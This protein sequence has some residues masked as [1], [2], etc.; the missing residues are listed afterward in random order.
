VAPGDDPVEELA[1][2]AELHD[3]VHG[4][5]VLVGGAEADDV[6]VRR[7]VAHDVHL[8]AHV[9]HVHGRAQLAL[10]DGLARVARPRGGLRAQV[11]DAELAAA[12]LAAQLVLRAEVPPRRVP[13]HHQA[14]ARRRRR[15]PAVVRHVVGVRLLLRLLLAALAALLRRRRRGAA[16]AH[17]GRRGLLSAA[18]AAKFGVNRPDPR[19]AGFSSFGFSGDGGD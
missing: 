18:A 2:L 14:R 17:G 15:R 7:H 16:V 12:Q 4:V 6:G 11:R 1:S 19:R 5:L 13:Q 3:E 9:L 10:G 8:P